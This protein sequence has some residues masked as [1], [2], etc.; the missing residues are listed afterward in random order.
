VHGYLILFLLYGIAG[1]FFAGLAY[2]VAKVVRMPLNLRWELAPVPHEKDKSRYGGSYFEDFEWWTKPRQYAH[3]NSVKYMLG[4]IFLLRGI[5]E[6]YRALWP[7]SFALHYGIYLTAVMAVFAVISVVADLAG[8]PET[9]PVLSGAAVILAAIGFTLGISGALGLLVRR[10]TS[11]ALR[12]YTSASSY[13][14]LVLLCAVFMTGAGTHIAGY[15]YIYELR[16]V[17]RAFLTFSADIG[18]SLPFAL[19]LAVS[20]LFLLYLPFSGMAHFIIKYFA[21]HDIRW[22]DTPMQD[23]ERISKKI[24]AQLLYPVSWKAPHVNGSPPRRVDAVNEGNKK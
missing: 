11:P 19:H 2:R 3:F 18:P 15:D 6:R 7:L 21:F 4:E 12:D 23:S 9:V 13:F 8:L 20:A 10:A 1:V 14:N 17:M 24:G 22:A 5:W 16:S